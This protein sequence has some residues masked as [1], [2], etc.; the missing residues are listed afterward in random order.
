MKNMGYHGTDRNGLA[1]EHWISLDTSTARV[2]FYRKSAN[3]V[4]I[5]SS[6]F[7]RVTG[8]QVPA[9]ELMPN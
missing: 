8:E 6:V 3:G 2:E 7:Y 4:G 9:D 1:C 5:S